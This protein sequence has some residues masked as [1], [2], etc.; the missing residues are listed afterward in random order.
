MRRLFPF[1][2]LDPG[3][4]GLLVLRLVVG[5]ALM[6]HGYPKIMVATHW[7]GPDTQVAG[8]LQA[9]SAL[10]EFGG[11]LALIL[12]FLTPIV[13]LGLIGNF[14]Y[15]LFVVHV[16]HHDPFVLPAGVQGESSELAVL[17]LANAIMFLF[18]GPGIHSI[19]AAIFNR[20]VRQIKQRARTAVWR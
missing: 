14:L 18:V 8:W 20:P 2:V 1:W 5:A 7:M 10:A 15:A 3:A 17:Y 11:G 9:L 12:G 19:D 6:V 13:C 16:A 4:L